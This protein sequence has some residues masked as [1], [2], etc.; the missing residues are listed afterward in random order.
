MALVIVLVALGACADAGRTPDSGA[1]RTVVIQMRDNHFEPDRVEARRGETIRFRFFNR[2]R[3]RHDARIGDVTAQRGHER[4]MTMRMGGDAEHGADTENA[5]TI[6]PGDS[7]DLTYRFAQRGETL[8]GCHEPGHYEGG[9]M[10]R[11]TVR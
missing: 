2:G 5:I 7:G 10:V 3:N 4:T 8:I 9:M 11:V 6:D 1:D